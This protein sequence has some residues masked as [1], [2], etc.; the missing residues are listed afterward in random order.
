MDLDAIVEE[1]Q[2]NNIA[3]ENATDRVERIELIKRGTELSKTRTA[4]I[5]NKRK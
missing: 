5:Q 1:I 2:Q 4:L 3:I